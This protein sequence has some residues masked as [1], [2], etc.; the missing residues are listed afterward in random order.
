MAKEKS[1]TF[2]ETNKAVAAGLASVVVA[3]FTS[4]LGVAGT[5]IGTALTAT[6]IT[7]IS[8]VLK[9]QMEKASQAIVD[10]PSTVQG[11]LSTQQVRIP[12]KQ[13][14]E[15]NPKPE[16]GERPPGLWSRLRSLP[17]FLRD[18][19]SAQRSKVLLAGVLAGLVATV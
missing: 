4:K 16:A 11:G 15:P 10:L 13:G 9:A 6:L 12:G 2:V 3:L 18:L 5:L 19:P 8:A 1:Q 7:L 14:P 17:G